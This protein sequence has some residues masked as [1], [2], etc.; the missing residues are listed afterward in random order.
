MQKLYGDQIRKEA[1][2]TKTLRTAA[3]NI[4][5]KLPKSVSAEI[6][7]HIREQGTENTR[8]KLESVIQETIE[9]VEKVFGDTN[10]SEQIKTD[11]IDQDETH[12]YCLKLAHFHHQAVA[13]NNVFTLGERI[14][15][16]WI[17]PPNHG[18]KDWVGIYRV[19]E[20][21]SKQTT[22]VSSRGKWY[23]VNAVK[24]SKPSIPTDEDDFLFPPEVELK[25]EGCIVFSG[26]KLPWREGTYEIRY[27]HDGKHTVMARSIPFEI[28]G[29]IMV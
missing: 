17:A 14:K 2:L 3:Q 15:V 8:K 4:P 26:D 7:K 27:H 9:R 25:T 28:A 24:P 22:S 1:G 29:S 21:P 5:K 13:S 11:D 10:I 12:H 16:D 18:P 6:E 20:N 19:T 23:W